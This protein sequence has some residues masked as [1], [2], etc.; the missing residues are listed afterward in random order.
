MI[1]KKYRLQLITAIGLITLITAALFAGNFFTP[2]NQPYGYV[3]SPTITNGS[4][5]TGNEVVYAPFFEDGT[6]T[7][8]MLALPV[9]SSGLVSVN[10]PFWRAK[11]KIASQN[12]D[13]G[14]YIVTANR[15]ATTGAIT[16]I[17]FRYCDTGAG[18]TRGTDC[19]TTAQE[20]LID[21]TTATAEKMIN[22]IRG[23]TANEISNG[24]TLRDRGSLLG[25]II[26]S[27]P[28]YVS[29]MTVTPSKIILPIEMLILLAA[30]G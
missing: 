6:F 5:T 10:N 7:G 27:T 1:M 15:D 18:D 30:A 20:A 22:F 2:N 17:P 25:D 23:E 19:L 14:R 26:H 28:Q 11:S 16:A 29:L 13:T 12:F 21:S 8:D 3:A 4:L 9:A 24:G